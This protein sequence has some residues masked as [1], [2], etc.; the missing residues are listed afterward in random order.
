M[1]PADGRHRPDKCPA[2]GVKH[3][4]HPQI[5]VGGGDVSVH[6]M[7]HD[8]QGSTAMRDHDTFGIGRRPAGV[9]DR[10]RTGFTDLGRIKLGFGRGQ[11]RFVIQPAGLTARE[12]HKISDAGNLIANPVNVIQILG[13]NTDHARTAVFQN[14]G[15][16][17]GVQSVIDRY[18]DRTD[19]RNC[20]KRFQVR[21]RIRRN[22]GD[23][24]TRLDPEFLQGR[25][26]PV[27]PFEEFSIGQPECP[28][29]NPYAIG[30]KS[31]SA[32]GKIE[33]RKRCLHG[34]FPG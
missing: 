12:R 9:V 1:S 32:T 17:G 29:N 21:M 19:L 8:V 30:V 13:M 24:I 18:H 22:T 28:V 27:T 6:Q 16:V 14:V 11:Q 33:R 7:P 3:R 23:S 5:P 26:P 10:D 34:E 4:Q 20:I 25:R 15:K 31:A 2:I